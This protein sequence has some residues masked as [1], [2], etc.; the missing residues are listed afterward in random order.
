MSKDISKIPDSKVLTYGDDVEIT[1]DA[2]MF[3]EVFNLASALILTE[4]QVMIEDD[5][6]YVKQM[7]E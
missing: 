1:M 2:G 4:V 5:G 7:E 3:K 6:L